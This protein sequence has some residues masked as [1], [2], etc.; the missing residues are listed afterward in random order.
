MGVLGL[1]FFV[2]VLIEPVSPNPAVARIIAGTAYLL[3]ATFIAEFLV[4]LWV[5]PDR[6][7]FLRRHWWRIIVLALPFLRLFQALRLAAVVR[8]VVSVVRGSTSA[9]RLLSERLAWM[10]A[11]T[12]L[13]VVSAGHMRHLTGVFPTYAEA[14]HGSAMATISGEPLGSERGWPMRCSMW[15]WPAT[16]WSSSRRWPAASALS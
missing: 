5:A 12:A 3:W 7:R 2:V 8:G 6:R 16:R 14:L 1:L 11:V 10:A 15:S 9:A 13:V 4:R